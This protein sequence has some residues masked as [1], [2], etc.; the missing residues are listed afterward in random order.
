[1]LTYLPKIH[2][3]PKFPLGFSSVF[4]THNFIKALHPHL[5]LFL[6]LETPTEDALLPT[7]SV[8][9]ILDKVTDSKSERGGQRK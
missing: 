8:T 3:S 7:I 6:P 4:D 2:A 1:M 5:G 9:L